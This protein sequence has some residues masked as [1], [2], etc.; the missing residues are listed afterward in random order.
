MAR[1]RRPTLRSTSSLPVTK[2]PKA[3]DG[4]D[5]TPGRWGTSTLK[6]HGLCVGLNA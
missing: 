3:T 4:T 6:T 5:Q 2:R 1:S